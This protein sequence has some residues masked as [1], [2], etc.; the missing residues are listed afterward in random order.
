MTESEALGKGRSTAERFAALN[1]IGIALMRELDESRLLHM[2]AQTARDLTDA[3][4]AAFSLRPVDVE[5]LPLVPAEGNLFYLAAVVGV[6][7]EQE[8]LFRRMPLGGEGL[9]APIFRHGVSVR[10]DDALKLFHPVQEA[11]DRQSKEEARQA[12]FAF[13]HGALP[14]DELRSIGVPRGHPIVRSF[15]GAPLL[16]RDQQVRGGLLLGHVEPQR[17]QAE[18]EAL[19]VGLAAQ[20]AVA[21]ENAR[22]YRV[23]QMSA[24]E[25]N[26][27]FESISDGVTL[28]DHTGSILREN[29]TARHLREVLLRCPDAAQVLQ[30]LLH[31]PARRTMEGDSS[32]EASASIVDDGGETREYIINASPLRRPAGSTGPLLEGKERG[33]ASGAV[34][35]WHDVTEAR[36]LLI[37]R[38]THAETEARRALLQLILDEL[39]GSVYLVRGPEARLVLINDAAA[40][41]WGA[42]W[43]IGQPM[44]HFL[45][46]HNI[47]IFSTEGQEM[48]AEQLATTRAVRQREIVRQ[49]Q[50]VIRQPN[51]SS[52]PV[53]VN[54]VPVDIEGI[55]LTAQEANKPEQRREP[56]ALVVHQDVTPLK[57][58]ERLKDDFIG[59]AAHELRSP[60]AVLKGFTQTLLMQTARGNGPALADWQLEA[61]QSIEQASLRMAELIDDLLD[62]TRLQAGRLALHPLPIDLVALTQRV[63]RRIRVTTEK[64]T[65]NVHPHQTYLVVEADPH[66][67]EQVLGN[68]L[69]NAIKYSPQGGEIEVTLGEDEQGY[70]RVSILDHGI[71]IPLEQQAHIFSRFMRGDNARE[72]GIGGTGLGLYLSRELIEQH[73]GAIWF[74]SEENKGSTFYITL[75][76]LHEEDD[77]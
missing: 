53:L 42:R 5:G 20:A 15:L 36:R 74:E 32:Y 29:S 18:D 70:G 3:S 56:A 24:Q 8:E 40:H 77:V 27:I 4:F 50:E 41:V 55:S 23:V 73:G 67:I 69:N 52:L 1:R 11:T 6:S 57:E 58:A 54:A 64:H 59:I 47:R 71:G 37:E 38:R 26:A 22:L 49:H 25:L 10:V 33:T 2:I 68:L 51:G 43:P 66:R 30:A 44:Q 62:V 13:S 9:L 61:L 63:V 28:V 17:F 16:D 19:L 35:V 39:P 7:P 21:I 48:M 72:R 12:A 45:Q 65:I 31:E 75:P 60:L 46:E 34:V 14:S 76:L